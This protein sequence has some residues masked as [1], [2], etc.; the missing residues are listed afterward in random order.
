M[1][2]NR[3]QAVKEL[4]QAAL[5]L[6][7]SA[8]ESF[9][10]EACARDDALRA[11]V[12]SLLAAHEAAGDFIEASPGMMETASGGDLFSGHEGGLT[13]GARLGPYEVLELLGRGGMGEVYRARDTRLGREIAVKVLRSDAAGK[14]ERLRLFQ[15]EAVAASALNHPNIVTVHDVG[16]VEARPYLTMELLR[17]RTLRAVLAARALTLR[18]L[19]GLARQVAEGLAA[20][21]AAGIVHRDLKPENVML[22]D[23]GLVKILDFGVAKRAV[24]SAAATATSLPAEPTPPSSTGV[25]GTLGYMS[26]EQARGEA[27]DFRSDQF[28]LGA[29][30]Y[31]MTAG[32]PAFAGETSRDLL[33]AI[34][35]PEPL[36]L[37]GLPPE[38]PA[39]LRKIIGRCLARRREDRYDSTREL[40]RA[41]DAVS[42]EPPAADAPARPRRSA[43]ASVLAVGLALI[44]LGV[45]LWSMRRPARLPVDSLAVMP[46]ANLTGDPAREYLSDGIT[47]SLITCLSEL[48]GMRV[49]ARNTVFRYKGRDVDAGEVG[50]ALHVRAVLLGR[51]V[52]L[53]ERVSIHAE[54]VDVETGSRLWSGQMVRA[55]TDLLALQDEVSG[56]LARA[57]R[58]KLGPEQDPA[59]AR[60]VAEDGEAYRLYLKGRY[61]A[62]RRTEADLNKAI[63]FFEQA[64]ARSPENARSLAGLADTYVLLSDYA[65]YESSGMF[66]K[67]RDAAL[68]AVAADDALAEGHTSLGIVRKSYDWDWR[69]AEWEFKRAIA[70]NPNHATAHHWY[71]I[72]LAS[73]GRFDAAVAELHAAEQ[74]DPFSIGVSQGLTHVLYWAG[75]YPEALE[76]S[77]KT[78]EL[79]PD[80]G[81]VHSVRALVYLAQGRTPEALVSVGEARRLTPDAAGPLAVWGYASARAGRTADARAALRDLIERRRRVYVPSVDLA[82]LYAALGEDEAA[83]GELERAYREHS[84]ALADIRVEPQLASLRSQPRF[85]ALVRRLGLAD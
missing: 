39:E 28:S 32:R 4:F 8:R 77:R 6:D 72:L 35:H 80:F 46:F 33:A 9:L 61:S 53:G 74:L 20:A 19:L 47:E 49:M 43:L 56:Q 52:P 71:G 16:T 22:T 85:Q 10:A 21:H 64:L 5:E 58:V 23:D 60:R 81:G 41:L 63:G 40:A 75:R 69:G 78:L 17:G 15:R 31:E 18:Q 1:S 2:V 3:W 44:G 83:L 48:P 79:H 62:S 26:P 34:L 76:Q 70:L 84:G 45:G 82:T 25:M 66:A 50:R 59:R 54:L 11:E 57:L 68:R 27:V 29:I 51:L 55:E 24:D 14:A 38:A 73:L 37:E 30:L 7:P 12:R 36:S 42:R 13:P 67:A 65:D